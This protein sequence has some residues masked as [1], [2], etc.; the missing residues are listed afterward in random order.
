MRTDD[1]GETSINCD[2]PTSDR[3]FLAVNL[4]VYV[5]HPYLTYRFR[6]K[7]G[8]YPDVAFPR[9][10]HEKIYWRKVF[11]RNPLFA[12]F[13][14]KLKT[15]AWFSNNFPSLAVVPPLWTGTRLDA[16]ALALIAKGDVVLKGN[17]GSGFNLFPADFAKGMPF[18][19]KTAR[20]WMSRNFARR[21]YQPAYRTADR[22]LFLEPLIRHDDAPVVDYYVRAAMGKVLAVSVLINAKRDGQK[23][24][25]FDEAGRRLA[26]LEPRTSKN[27]LPPD[28]VPPANY[29]AAMAHA[30]LI[31]REFDFLRIDFMSN[32]QELYAG[33]VTVY[34]NAG[35]TRADD[36]PA[37]DINALTNE[38]WD[39]RNSHFLSQRNPSFFLEHYK[40]RLGAALG[41]ASRPAA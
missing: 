26:H 38:G 7:V 31:S 3:L 35:M 34:P 19:K 18:V 13:S 28:F 21:Y 23:Y 17:H 8:Y 37:T 32:G 22:V 30:R 20:R 40:L 5:R 4:M 25:Y 27:T 41:L 39:L 12:D 10:Y 29:A 14:D 2:A 11:D 1:I 36:N 16:A 9:R 33:E 24:G 6:Q 15:K